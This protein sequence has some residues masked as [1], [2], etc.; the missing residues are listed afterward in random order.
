MRDVEPDAQQF[1]GLPGTGEPFDSG[2]V[3]RTIPL[4]A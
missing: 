1:G 2:V 4:P 3:R